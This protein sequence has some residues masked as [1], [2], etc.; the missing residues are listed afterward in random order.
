MHD[1]R[2]DVLVVFSSVK[3]LCVFSYID[4]GLFIFLGVFSFYVMFGQPVTPSSPLPF[5]GIKYFFISPILQC[6]KL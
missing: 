4:K 5:V 6:R 3:D 1:C 2:P